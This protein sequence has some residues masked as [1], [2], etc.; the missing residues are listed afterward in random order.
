MCV[1]TQLQ[2]L[3]GQWACCIRV[4]SPSLNTVSALHVWSEWVCG[5]HTHSADA[6]TCAQRTREGAA[7]LDHGVDTGWGGVQLVSDGLADCR[8]VRLQH[9]WEQAGDVH[10]DTGDC[11]GTLP[12]ETGK[13]RA[14]VNE[15]YYQY[16]EASPKPGRNKVSSHQPLIC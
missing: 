4:V 7:A 6:V 2:S 5:V 3:L 10:R 15:V 9:R 16:A 8:H 11:A 13:W 12:E 14:V 1:L